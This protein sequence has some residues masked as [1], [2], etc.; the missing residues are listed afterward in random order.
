M[1]KEKNK[2]P[3]VSNAKRA[4]EAGR[5]APNFTLSSAPDQKVS[6]KDFRGRPVILTFYPVSQFDKHR[7][8]ISLDQSSDTDQSKRA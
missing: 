7:L 1:S 2:S 4:L 8:P 6:L 5:S 3:E